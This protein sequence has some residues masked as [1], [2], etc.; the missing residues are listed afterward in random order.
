MKLVFTLAALEDLRS[1]RAYT[2]DTWGAE[3]ENHYLGQMWSRFESLRQDPD[4]YRQRPD[5][6]PGCSIAAEGKHVILF[7]A[8]PEQI[9]IVRVLH[10]AMDFKRHLTSDSEA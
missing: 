10:S 6:F 8:D 9:E 4:R 7:R 2:F 3:Q 1:I 5:L